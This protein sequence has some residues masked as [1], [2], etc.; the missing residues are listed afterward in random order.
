MWQRSWFIVFSQKPPHKMEAS[1]YKIILPCVHFMNCNFW[2]SWYG[3]DAIRGL[4][5]HYLISYKWQQLSMHTHTQT[6]G[7]GKITNV[8]LS[9]GLKLCTVNNF[10]WRNIYA[11]CERT[12]GSV[13]ESCFWFDSVK[14][15]STGNRH[16]NF[17]TYIIHL[18]EY[19]LHIVYKPTSTNMV[20]GRRKLDVMS[21]FK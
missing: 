10:G 14:S 1:V 13:H 7:V 5:S 12:K 17:H 15:W 6:C 3:H 2:T 9:Q 4:L 11:E 16:V 21:N 20:T 18:P 8:I 19:A